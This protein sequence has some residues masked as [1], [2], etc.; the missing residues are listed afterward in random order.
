MQHRVTWGVSLAAIDTVL[1]WCQVPSSIAKAV[2]EGERYYRYGVMLK[3]VQSYWTRNLLRP[4][5]DEC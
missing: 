2:E 1:A 5:S 3:K 4:H